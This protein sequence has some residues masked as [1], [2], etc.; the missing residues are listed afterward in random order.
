MFIYYSVQLYLEDIEINLFDISLP[1]FRSQ[2]KYLFLLV[3]TQEPVNL[4]TGLTND[5]LSNSYPPH[6]PP[7]YS[8]NEDTQS[9]T[10][11]SSSIIPS[12]IQMRIR[13]KLV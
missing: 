11:M 5:L 7:F 3:C 2:N 13:D 4:F 1:F 12:R 8:P 6:N 9:S 10:H